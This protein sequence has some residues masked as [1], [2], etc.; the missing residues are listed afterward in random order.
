MKIF[1]SIVTVCLL[2][3]FQC[4][5]KTTG[6]SETS[7]LNT[8]AGAPEQTEKEIKQDPLPEGR[9]GKISGKVSHQFRK[10]GCSTVII[11]TPQDGGQVL[12]LIPREKLN[13]DFDVDGLEIIF[14]YSLLKMPNPPGCDQGIPAEITDVRKR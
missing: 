6:K 9:A 12:I 2:L 5:Q 11:I 13:H 1:V 7:A 8:D 14:N 4:K 3:G 10:T